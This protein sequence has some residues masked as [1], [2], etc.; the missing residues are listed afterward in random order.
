M[1]Q[2]LL[3]HTLLASNAEVFTIQL[4]G[5]V[6]TRLCEL[7]RRLMRIL[8][9]QNDNDR[10]DQSRNVLLEESPLFAF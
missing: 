6:G 1:S 7:R 4:D 8:T 9:S 3:C 10:F 5:C 2:G